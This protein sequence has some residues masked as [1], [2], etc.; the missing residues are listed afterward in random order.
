MLFTVASPAYYI[1][2][3]ITIITCHSNSFK[4]YVVAQECVATMPVKYIRKSFAM[5]CVCARS[6]HSPKQLC[7]CSSCLQYYVREEKSEILGRLASR[8]TYSTRTS[9]ANQIFLKLSYLVVF[10]D[11]QQLCNIKHMFIFTYWI[12][13]GKILLFY[14]TYCGY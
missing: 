8:L 13:Y 14:V 5:P 6:P 9:H 4:E 3:E 11:G 1:L 12:V 10:D 7:R 2:K